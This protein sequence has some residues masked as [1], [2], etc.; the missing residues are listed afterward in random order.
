MT[1]DMTVTRLITFP[2]CNTV[3]TPPTHRLGA[4]SL[5]PNLTQ[6][7]MKKRTDLTAT[8]HHTG[9]TDLP[10][11]PPPSLHPPPPC[12]PTPLLQ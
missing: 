7:S 11:L 1:L 4:H 5:Q 8:S 10:L 3:I 12:R 2:E 6:S 9:S